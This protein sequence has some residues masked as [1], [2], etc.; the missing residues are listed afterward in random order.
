MVAGRF[1]VIVKDRS[2]G[3]GCKNNC[4]FHNV[5][6]FPK[7]QFK[8]RMIPSTLIY[9]QSAS[10]INSAMVNMGEVQKFEYLNDKKKHFGKWQI[11]HV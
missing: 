11:K 8:H 4:V 6:S 3:R 1:K 9:R 7:I 2:K 5:W 10:P